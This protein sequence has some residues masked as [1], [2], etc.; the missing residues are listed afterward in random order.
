MLAARERLRPSLKTAEGGSSWR[1]DLGIY[2]SGAEGLRGSVNLSPAWFQ[3]GHDV[4]VSMRKMFFLAAYSK[5]G[6]DARL[7][8]CLG[9]LQFGCRIGMARCHLRIKCDFERNPGCNPPQSL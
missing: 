6:K 1:D 9:K 8:T 5:S 7:P 3:L 4:S 2:H